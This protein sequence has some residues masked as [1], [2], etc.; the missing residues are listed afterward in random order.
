MA[1]DTL[2][3]WLELDRI[4]CHDEGDGWG[5]AEPYLWTV[6]FKIDGDTVAL[7]ESLTLSGTPTVVTTPGSHGNLGDTDVD[8]GDD[9]TIPSAVGEWNPFL[10]PIPVPES[11]RPLVGDDLP[12]VAGVVCVLMEEDNVTDAGADA[13]HAALDA[14]VTSALTDIIA[15]RSFSN[16]D[17]TE[18][19]IN[20]YM[21]AVRDAVAEAVQSQQSFFENLWSWLN[22]DDTV[23]TVVLFWD[24]DD[25][26]A[27]EPIEFSQRWQ[28]EGD[29]ELFGHVNATVV[30]PAEAAGAASA[31]IDAIFS[32]VSGDMRRFR[33][34]EVGGTRLQ[35]WWSLAERNSPQL[36][37]VL[38]RD[39]RL[40]ESTAALMRALPELLDDRGARL[41]EAQVAHARRILQ[42]LREV[43][44][45][46][47]RVDAGR[48]LDVLGHLQGKTVRESIELLSSVQPGRTPRPVK[49]I[50]HLLNPG[51]RTPRSVLQPIQPPR[52]GTRGRE[53][54]DT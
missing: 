9:I 12:G 17:I 35:Q 50:G 28:D 38:R 31:I 44:S 42:Q 15:T 45:R 20:Q 40:V 18:E 3:V 46:Q 36:S 6:F 19:E 23:G 25:L 21:G 53:G 5:S 11:L 29:W 47:A 34:R 16:P 27:G 54:G 22:E 39:P 2:R 30:C 48:A 49:D 32:Q 1:R 7:T 52:P 14:A 43:G 51:L 33:D 37:Y 41:S 24:Q 8:A 26:A 10:T 4:H 13:G